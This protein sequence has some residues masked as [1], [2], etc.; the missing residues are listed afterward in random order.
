MAAAWNAVTC[1]GPW[2]ESEDN[3]TALARH[4]PADRPQVTKLAR[5]ISERWPSRKS[6]ALRD[7]PAVGSRGSRPGSAKVAAASQK[8]SHHNLSHYLAL[9]RFLRQTNAGEATRVHAGEHIQPRRAVAALG[10][11]GRR[12]QKRD[13][14]ADVTSGSKTAADRPRYEEAADLC[15]A[16]RHRG[17]VAGRPPRPVFDR[18]PQHRQPAA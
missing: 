5:S 2:A 3:G 6:R 12:V 11:R 4:R 1:A 17:G 14:F 10:P 15:R 9:R 13:V 8:S 16:G 7:S 18:L